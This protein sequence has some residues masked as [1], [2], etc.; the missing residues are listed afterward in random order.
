MINEDEVKNPEN[1][2][3]ARFTFNGNIIAEIGE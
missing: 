1:L 3:P 2:G